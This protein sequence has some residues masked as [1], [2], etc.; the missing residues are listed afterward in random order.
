MPR[1]LRSDF[2][3]ITYHVINRANARLQIF[4]S[5]KEYSQF[6][7]VL[8]EARERVDMRIY[9]YVIMPN[10]WHLIVS[11]REDGVLTQFMAWLTMTHTQRWHRDH[12]SVGTGHLYQGRYKSFPIDTDEYFLTACRYVE[13]NPLRAQLVQRAEEW[14]WGSLWRREY[15]SEQKKSL[16]STWSTQP[17]SSYLDWVNEQESD[18]RLESLR[19]CVNRGQ[20]FGS[21][22]WTDS[23]TK[24]FG[25]ESTFRS[26][27]RPWEKNNGS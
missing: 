7:D 3:D 27:G 1:P 21:E 23:I 25:L 10:H 13:Q 16:L 2:A 20:P 14:M 26:I 22:A 8:S 9:A 15:G 17:Q 24:R 6:E 5:P 12:Q 11:P 4:S 19:T 18:G